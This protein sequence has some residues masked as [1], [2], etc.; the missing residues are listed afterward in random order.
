MI[1][2][3]PGAGPGSLRLKP[4]PAAEYYTDNPL[5]SE[6]RRDGWML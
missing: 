6:I 2:C 3:W 4:F 5:M 1:L